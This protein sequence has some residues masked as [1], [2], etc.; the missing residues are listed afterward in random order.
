MTLKV[1]PAMNLVELA[2][3]RKSEGLYLNC[4][5]H[6]ILRGITHARNQAPGRKIAEGDRQGLIRQWQ[7]C[8]SKSQEFPEWHMAG[9]TTPCRP[10]GCAHRRLDRSHGFRCFGGDQ[11]SP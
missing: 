2:H 3:H 8:R 6:L 10:E 7:P 9:R 11:Q 1:A 4:I 5:S